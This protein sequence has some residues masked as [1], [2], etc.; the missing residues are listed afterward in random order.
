MASNVPTGGTLVL[1]SSRTDPEAAVQ[2]EAGERPRLDYLALADALHGDV[3][4]T[5]VGDALPGWQRRL[6]RV[7]SS[8]IAQARAAWGRRG[9][10]GSWLSTSEKVGLPLALLAGRRRSAAPH[11]LIAHNLASAR[12]RQMNRL[13]GVLRWGFSD[14]VC[15]SLVQQ[16]FLLG[17]VG[18]PPERVHHIPHNVDTQFFRP[19]PNRGSEGE[20]L[21]AVGRENR[22]YP[23]L[24]AA[25]RRLGLPL[26]LV[27]SSL[28]AMRGGAV[29]EDDL[30]PN[31]TVRREFVSYTALRDLYAGARLVVVPLNECA[32]AAGSTGLLEAMAMGRPAVVSRTQG[33][34]DY[35]EDPATHRSTPPGD[36]PML[37]E[38]IRALWD[39]APTRRAMGA[40]AREH[41]AAHMSMEGYVARVAAV[42]RHA[43]EEERA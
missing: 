27:A 20:Y 13:T 36:V 28:W 6:E 17:E 34:A 19:D 4:D 42:V 24:I 1:A 38:A 10:Y 18:L 37:A 22:D 5:R 40:A 41:V 7:L 9:L 43:A 35:L 21:L 25:A 29:S 15:V 3:L 32:Y 30:P 2:S 23:T 39:D 8:D 12:K 26:I 16:A 11:V 31:V 14:I 33:L